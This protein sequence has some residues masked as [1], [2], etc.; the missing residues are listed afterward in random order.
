MGL[1]FEDWLASA[2]PSILR[3][4]FDKLVM[5]AYKTVEQQLNDGARVLWL[6]V[7]NL[8][9]L[10]RGEFLSGLR[11]AGIQLLDNRRML[12]MLPS[13]TS[14]SRRAM[15]AGRLPADSLHFSDDES[16]CRELWRERGVSQIAYCTSFNQVEQ[17]IGGPAPLVVF[18]YNYL[19]TL[20]HTPEQ[21]GFER[22]EQMTLAMERLALRTAQVLRRMRQAGPARLVVSTD[23]GSTHPSA[24][25]QVIST[26]PSATIGTD[27]EEHRRYVVVSETA[28]LNTT[29]WHK[30]EGA[31]CGLPFTVAVARGQRYVGSRPRAFVHGGLSP[32]ETVVSLIV[33]D[34]DER[35]ALRIVLTQATPPL[36]RGRPGQ[37]AILVRNP[38][39]VPVEDLVLSLPQYGVA[40]NPL[41][42]PAHYEAA[43]EERMITLE[44]DLEVQD[45]VARITC[46][47][48]YLLVG[49]PTVIWEPVQITVSELYRP[50]MDD[51][52]EMFNA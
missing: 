27:P 22:E 36:R 34:I 15:L 13:S 31:D 2:Y 33:A 30:L 52:G 24:D 4:S 32:E 6:V 12:S 29:D 19:D 21:P 51:F 40:F 46:T 18:L 9:G 11:K 5:A 3:D 26:P 14:V 45:G 28:G 47:G 43:T 20:A 48:R 39:D 35:E 25:S 44:P 37:I 41:D 38:F 23:H 1:A 10:W 50:A 42:V 49:Q 8:S 16:A 7:D 17:A